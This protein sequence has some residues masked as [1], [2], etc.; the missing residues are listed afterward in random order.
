MKTMDEEYN[1][2]TKKMADAVMEYAS[3]F[4]ARSFLDEYQRAESNLTNVFIPEDFDKRV[5]KK[6]SQ[7]PRRQRGW[8]KRLVRNIVVLFLTFFLLFCVGTTGVVLF[9]ESLR[10]GLILTILGG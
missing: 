5:Y 4:V 2:T 7:L 3:Q 1:R 8:G 6:I 10:S 9:S